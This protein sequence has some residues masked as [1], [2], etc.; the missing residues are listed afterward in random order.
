MSDEIFGVDIAAIVN[1]TFAG[2][3]HPLTLHKITATVGDYGEP[4]NSEVDHDGEGVRSKWKSE[5]MVSRGYAL[6]TVKIIVLQG[7]IVE[8]TNDDAITI[9]GERFRIVDIEKDPVNAT[10]SLAAVKV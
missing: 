4:I 2:N 5:I 7:G 10:W 1:D 9:Q 6:G 8:P 3:L